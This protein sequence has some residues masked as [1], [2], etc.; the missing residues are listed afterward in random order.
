MSSHS[1]TNNL[2]RKPVRDMYGRYVGQVISISFD[3]SGD[4]TA[5]QVGVG[6]EE[7]EEYKT[8]L[9]SMNKD[10]VVLIPKWKVDTKIIQQKW[11]MTQRKILA[12]DNLLKSGKIS[13]RVCENLRKREA[14][15][16]NELRKKREVLLK[17]LKDRFKKLQLYTDKYERSIVKIELEREVGEIDNQTFETA[18]NS[19][20]SLLESA[21]SE[22][23]DIEEK[24]DQLI[25]L[26]RAYL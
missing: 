4:L 18:Y 13:Q 25:K 11:N 3:P 1:L 10:S 26:D 5:I 6:S 2:L 20:K 9:V 12:L 7:I 24:L 22:R 19:I 15:L 17:G 23:K 16:I 21:L 14:E 8:T